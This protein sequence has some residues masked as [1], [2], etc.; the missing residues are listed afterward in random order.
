[1]ETINNNVSYE[2]SNI[3]MLDNSGQLQEADVMWFI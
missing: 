3:I 2:N 1:M